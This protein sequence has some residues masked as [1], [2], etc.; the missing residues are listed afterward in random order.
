MI[1]SLLIIFLAAVVLIA[2]AGIGLVVLIKL[3][4][5]AKY[6]FK[7]EPPDRGAYNLDQSQEAGDK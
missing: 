2:V 1:A 6:A 7:E 4:V 3:G 5:I